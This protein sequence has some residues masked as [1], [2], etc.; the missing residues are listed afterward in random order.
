[1]KLAADGNNLLKVFYTLK[2]KI[3]NLFQYIWN[4]EFRGII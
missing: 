4:K 3:C 2:E 1:M